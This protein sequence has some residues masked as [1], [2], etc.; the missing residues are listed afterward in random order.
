MVA[1]SF[2]VQLHEMWT[3]PDCLDHSYE[4]RRLK[5]RSHHSWRK[6]LASGE[7]QGCEAQKLVPRFQLLLHQV[8]PSY[9]LSFFFF[10]AFLAVGNGEMLS[11]K[12]GAAASWRGRS[13][14]S[15]K[16]KREPRALET[17]PK[18]TSFWGSFF[19]F[20]NQNTPK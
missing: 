17:Q 6:H 11:E 10:F 15:R 9:P 16:K 19:F 7:E 2:P 13:P 1:K 8:R 5:L 12:R 4:R 3:W 20:L 18:T 14:A